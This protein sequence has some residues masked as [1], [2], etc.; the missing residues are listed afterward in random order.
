MTRHVTPFT[1]EEFIFRPRGCHDCLW[2]ACH[3]CDLPN[4]DPESNSNDH[5]PQWEFKYGEDW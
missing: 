1:R 2:H 5:C 3:A 4:H